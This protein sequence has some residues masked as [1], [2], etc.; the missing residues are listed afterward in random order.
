MPTLLRDKNSFSGTNC[1]SVFAFF[2]GGSSSSA[3]RLAGIGGFMGGGGGTDLF[4]G[5]TI[6]GPG[7][8][9]AWAMGGPTVG[10]IGGLT[11]IKKNCKYHN[12]H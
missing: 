1:S 9:G 10:G 5:D 7:I 12:D 8:K 6:G 11:P 3:G 4:I 2:D